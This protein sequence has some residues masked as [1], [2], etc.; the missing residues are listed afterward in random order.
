MSRA[1][2]LLILPLTLMLTGCW[3]GPL[4]FTA[5]D[6]AKFLED[7]A[8]RLVE[9]GSS[10]PGGDVLNIRN[11]YDG[12]LLVTGPDHPWR[13]LTV[14]LLQAGS[15]RFIL[16]LQESDP[17]RPERSIKA[18]YMLL[19]MRRQHP[20]ITILACDAET[21]GAVEASGGFIARDPQSAS[22]CGFTDGAVLKQRIAAA[23]QGLSEPDIELIRV[24]E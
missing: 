17:K 5:V 7:G 24:A 12:S 8:Y 1:L 15:G 18:T 20:A 3:T 6:A 16:Q 23:G 14:P 11:Q 2:C 22:S 9:P 10:D 19:D 21:A 13:V 4:L